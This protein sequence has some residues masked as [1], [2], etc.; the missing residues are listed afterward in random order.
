MRMLKSPPLSRDSESDLMSQFEVS[1]YPTILL[2]ENNVSYVFSG[3]RSMQNL[4]E[5]ARGSYKNSRSFNVTEPKSFLGRIWATTCRVVDAFAMMMDAI[6][7]SFLPYAIRAGLPILVLLS[8]LIGIVLCIIFLP[9]QTELVAADNA[10]PSNE[11]AQK[12]KKE[13]GEAEKTKRKAE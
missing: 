9:D 11:E 6:G 7:L 13:A 1:G 3:E 10:K 2:V 8:P 12:K 5:F 4:T